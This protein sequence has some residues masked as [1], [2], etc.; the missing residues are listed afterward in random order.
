MKDWMGIVMNGYLLKNYPDMTYCLA[1][2]WVHYMGKPWAPQNYLGPFDSSLS[3]SITM[4]KKISKPLKIER[5]LMN[6][7]NILGI[8]TS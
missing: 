2:I 1:F 5:K 3:L 7:V 6:R 4:D 8:K